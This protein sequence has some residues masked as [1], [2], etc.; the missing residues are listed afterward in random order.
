MY[1]NNR[2][3]LYIEKG[4]KVQFFYCFREFLFKNKRKT[5]VSQTVTL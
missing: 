2:G 5:M 1:K 4:K 3:V